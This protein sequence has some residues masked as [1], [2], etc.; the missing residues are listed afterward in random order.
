MLQHNYDIKKNTTVIY[1]LIDSDIDKTTS[2]TKIN[3][4]PQCVNEY[5]SEIKSTI[6]ME[7]NVALDSSKQKQ[8]VKS[9]KGIKKLIKVSPLGFSQQMEEVIL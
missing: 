1:C 7:E 9:I 4:F 2:E 5:F 8:F 3:Y 6:K